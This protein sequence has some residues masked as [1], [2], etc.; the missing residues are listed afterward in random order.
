MV[1]ATELTIAGLTATTTMFGV[2]VTLWARGQGRQPDAADAQAEAMWLPGLW[3]VA[4]LAASGGLLF[5]LHWQTRGT[6]YRSTFTSKEVVY[7]AA[8]ASIS[9]VMAA[10][11]TAT[12]FPTGVLKGQGQS[13]LL[14]ASVA[15][16][17]VSV[18]AYLVRNFGCRL[19]NNQ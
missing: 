3:A 1:N 19:C 15:V 12:M 11:L 8:T 18:I 6:K 4:S 9:A 5:F 16:L 2:T 17:V 13:T 7:G 10:L 14:Q